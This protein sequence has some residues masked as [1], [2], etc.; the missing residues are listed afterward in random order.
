M[1]ANPINANAQRELG[2]SIKQSKLE[3]NNNKPNSQ[4]QALSIQIIEAHLLS[5]MKLSAIHY[6]ESERGAF[7]AAV[8]ELMDRLPMV[9]RWKTIRQSYQS[10]TRTRAIFYYIP[11]D[12]L[13]DGSAK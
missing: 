6:Q 4:H 2:S 9:A 11:Q 13:R 8:S 5:G 3:T 10:Q 1:I 7:I 12:F